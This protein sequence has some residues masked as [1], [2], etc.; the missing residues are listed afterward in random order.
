MRIS[1]PLGRRS[2]IS[3]GPI[4]LLVVVP[5][6][7]AGY[8]LWFLVMLLVWL[9]AGVARLTRYVARRLV[10]YHQLLRDAKHCADLGLQGVPVQRPAGRTPPC[11]LPR[12]RRGATLRGAFWLSVATRG[13]SAP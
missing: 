1:V 13:Y 6:L 11:E 4:G 10:P 9:V 7:A 2:R 3:L 5:F 8:V 12:C